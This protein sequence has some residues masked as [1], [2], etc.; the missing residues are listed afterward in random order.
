M[1]AKATPLEDSPAVRDLKTKIE[2]RV[3]QINAHTERQEEL[4]AEFTELGQKKLKLV[5]QI[6]LLQEEISQAMEPPKPS[7][8][9]RKKK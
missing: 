7:R 1:T 5:G 3:D 4:R 8:N 9:G 6:E 2:A